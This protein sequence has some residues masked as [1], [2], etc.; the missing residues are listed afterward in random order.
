MKLL[1]TSLFLICLLIPNDLLYG[2]VKDVKE[3]VKEDKENTASGNADRTSDSNDDSSGNGDVSLDIGFMFDLVGG[4]FK[5]LVLGQKAALDYAP[6]YPHRISVEAFGAYGVGNNELVNR[7]LTGGLQANW[8]IFA[9]DIRLKSLSDA[10][11]T[12]DLLD[13]QV[14]KIR[15]PIKNVHVEY[16]L[17]Y[18]RVLDEAQN[19]FN[20]TIGVVLD[21]NKPVLSIAANYEWSE[22]SSLGSRFLHAWTARVDY[23]AW[24]K[25]R[26]GIGPLI[27]LQNLRFFEETT[28]FLVNFGIVVKWY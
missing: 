4:V 9:S 18:L 15:I 25:H 28:F 8:G 11:G 12:L 17:G 21:L 22:R 26:I 1:Y 5:G 7:Y 13:W 2:Q 27:E 6:Y 23:E 14:L 20:N 24:T 19:Y 10:S 3:K 16:G